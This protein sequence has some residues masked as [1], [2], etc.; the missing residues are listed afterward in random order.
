[1]KRFTETDKW[2]D[3]WFRK[4]PG[5]HKLVFIFL[6]ENCNNAGFYELDI[7]HVAYLTGLE[8]RHVEGALKALERGI[9]GASGWVW[10]KNFLRHQKNE[11][12]NIANPAHRQILGLIK[13]QMERFLSVPDFEK[14]V[15]PYKGLLSPIGTVQVKDRKESAERKPKSKPSELPDLP[16]AL[17]EVPGF[18]EIWP[19]FILHRKQ[20]RKPLTPLAAAGLFKT[21]CERPADALRA[22]ETAIRRSWQ[23]FEWDW[24]E[25]D[26]QNGING[27]A[28]TPPPVDYT[29][30]W[31]AW[32]KSNGHGFREY[33][34][35]PDFLKSDFHKDRKA[36]KT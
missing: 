13:V 18:A 9:Q 3:P 31:E 17:A 1:M 35:A 8:K 19:S 16:P 33:Q 36:A 32:L 28:P 22:I 20:I 25:N 5:V 7:D 11:E 2:E 26:R 30:E 12:L 21:L 27:H 29:E 23:G 10:V 14:F 34:F 15:A 24:L 6:I 4:L